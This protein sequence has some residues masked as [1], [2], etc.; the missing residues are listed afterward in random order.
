MNTIKSALKILVF[1]NLLIAMAAAAQVWLSYIIFNF[2]PNFYIVILEGSATLILYNFSIWLSKPNQPHLSPYERTRW[3]FQ[4]VYILWINTI[5]ASILL[6]FCGWHIHPYLWLYLGGVGLLSV[7]Y[8]FPV[9]PYKGKYV[10]L[11]QLPGVKVFHIAIVWMLSVVGLPLI[12]LYLQGNSIDRHIWIYLAILKILFLLI[13]TL[14]FDIRD[15]KQ[16]SYYHL[17]TIPT[18]VGERIAIYIC[19]LLLSVHAG[20]WLFSSF[21]PTIKWGLLTTDIFILGVYRMLF[22]AR[23][24]YLYTFLLDA[25]LVLQLVFVYLAIAIFQ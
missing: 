5:A 11:R 7:G 19:L 18:L 20:I 9:I 12:D 17:K 15:I 1:S 23:S 6:L 10:G 13:C 2:P 14:P 8:N 24:S 3:V 22:S 25:M 4:H 16:D 21:D